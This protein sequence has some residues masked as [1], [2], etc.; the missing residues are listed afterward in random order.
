MCRAREGL[1]HVVRLRQPDD[2]FGTRDRG[3]EIA[4]LQDVARVE[5]LRAVRVQI[6]TRGFLTQRCTKCISY[7]LVAA[8]DHRHATPSARPIATLRSPQAS[9]TT[10]SAGRG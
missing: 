3:G 9:E 5:L 8:R 1:E 4:H 2:L 7:L 6:W 10:A